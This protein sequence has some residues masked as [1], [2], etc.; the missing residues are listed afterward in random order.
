VAI[1]TR[2]DLQAAE[3]FLAA[4]GDGDWEAIRAMLADGVQLRA[5][6]PSALRE[7]EGPDAVIERFRVWW[8]ELEDFRVVESAVA[9][10]ADQVRVRYLLAGIDRADGPVEVEQQCYF[11]FDGRITKI[12]SVCSGFRPADPQR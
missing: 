2:R 12:N 11:T 1:A 5:L 4:L 10:A 7:A 8:G 3:H 6:V 9:P